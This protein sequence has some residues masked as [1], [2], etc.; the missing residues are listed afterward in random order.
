ME[1]GLFRYS[2]QEDDTLSII[3]D[4][5]GA[6]PSDDFNLGC[7]FLCYGLE[8]EYREE[9]VSGETRIPSG[10]YEIKFRDVGGM[11][12]RYAEKYP[13]IHQ[14]MLWLQ[15]VPGFEWIYIHVGNDDD[16]TEGCILVG[17]GIQANHTGDEGGKVWSSS[18]AY[19]RLYTRIAA[20]INRD[21]EVWITICNMDRS[22]SRETLAH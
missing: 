13:D 22:V 7:E 11:T 2:S 18:D 20:A 19:I 16:H 8:D 12:K 1:L 15:D 3:M 10:K 14:G 6:E 17:D 5:T 9:K 4:L 21:E